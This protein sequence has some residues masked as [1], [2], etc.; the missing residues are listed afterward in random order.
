[1]K[2]KQKQAP[3]CKYCK[4]SAMPAA[5]KQSI[6]QC[7][8]KIKWIQLLRVY[9]THTKYFLIGSN[10]AETKFK[11]LKIDRTEPRELVLEQDP[12]EYSLHEVKEI[13]ERLHAGNSGKTKLWQ[14]GLIQTLTAF[15][16]VGFVRFLE[17]YYMILITRRSTV[18]ELGGHTIYKVEDTSM[19][20][21]PNSTVRIS[22]TDESRYLKSF[23]TVDLS[24]HFYY[25]YSYDLSNSLQH[26][27]SLQNALYNNSTLKN[28]DD[29]FFSDKLEGS[30]SGSTPESWKDIGSSDENHQSQ[31]SCPS[32][33][34]HA[35]QQSWVLDPH[36]CPRYVWN[37]YLKEGICDTA[38]DNWLLDIIHGFIGQIKINIYGKPVYVTLIA[39]RS[40]K[41]AGTR[42]L[43][44][45]C[46]IHGDVANEVE[47]EQIVHS[48]TL[49]SF[50]R[51]QYT[52]YVQ[53]RGSIPVH[54]FQ[55]I[56][57]NMVPSKPQITIAMSNPYAQVTARHFVPLIKRFGSPIVV[58]NLVRIRE[59]RSRESHLGEAFKGAID[60]LNLFLPVKHA[61]VYQTLDMAHLSHSTNANV[62]AK[63]A[64][65]AEEN[66][67]QTGI[68]QNN[69][70]L[71]QSTLSKNP[72]WTKL[73]GE[74]VGNFRLQTGVI[75]SN[76]VD[77]LDRTNSAQFIL[78][79]CALAYQLYALGVL[80]EPV[81]EFD[82]DA[83]RLFEELFEEHGDIIALQYGGSQ[84]VHTI[85]SYRQTA[86]LASHSRDIVTTISRYYNNTF[87]DSYKQ[88]AINLFLGIYKPKS[89]DDFPLWDLVTDNYLHNNHLDVLASFTASSYTM[90]LH[91]SF[92]SSLPLPSDFVMSVQ[93]LSNMYNHKK[94]IKLLPVGDPR[95]DWFDEF[96]R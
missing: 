2:P 47:T 18:A 66:L 61:I 26:N 55:D 77:C 79:K 29:L 50:L 39:R 10:N 5:S 56:T 16:I 59:R 92:Q 38:K 81:I 33:K 53:Y 32:N 46:N 23:Q 45:G 42:F 28:K 37:N 1:M 6:V 63:L 21:I 76:C 57:A 82:T 80:P 25:S 22:H 75:R 96:Y 52:A 71:F 8:F 13:I 85:Q 15:G 30:S 94:E 83:T 78:A 36:A 51:G 44:R 34:S 70:H 93:N 91:T 4:S 43:K 72:E 31:D 68:F 20:Y 86:V 89:D 87:S 60:Y 67:Q 58:L 65:I 54:W 95:V 40:S 49:T 12:V 41:Y 62:L 7:H 74:Q 48:A 27:V 88:A 84:L 73:K 69:I 3:D 11:I 64:K 9:K 90:W 19:T 17:G 24:S 35:S 14:R